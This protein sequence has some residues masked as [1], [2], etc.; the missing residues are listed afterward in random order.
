MRI[1]RELHDIVA[2]T[3]SAVTVQM[4]VAAAAFD[5]E[6]ATART[7]LAD[8]RSSA[9]NAMSELRRSV[10]VLREDR[11]EPLAPVSR[12]DDVESFAATARAAGITVDVV[13]RRPGAGIPATVDLAAARIVQ[14]A[15]T[16]VVRHSGAHRALVDIGADLHRL[17]VEVSDDGAGS[18]G[19]A[20]SGAGHGIAGM[21]ER[22]EALGGRL[23]VAD[24]PTG[25]FSVRAELPLG[26][27]A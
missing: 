21:R 2:H 14:E 23:D 17:V 27:P 19:A 10:A 18:G 7:A 12:L 26:G 24:L 13:D 5:R 16:N 11:D 15:L 3:M 9:K 8:A 22:A 6:P 1:A 4:N 25:G 20:L